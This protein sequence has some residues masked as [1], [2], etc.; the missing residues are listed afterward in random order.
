[1]ALTIHA[2]WDTDCPRKRNGMLS[3]VVGAV[4]IHTGAFNSP[5]KLPLAGSRL[6]T[7]PARSSLWVR[8]ATTGRARFLVPM[9]GSCV[10]D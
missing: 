5:L 7:V 6:A 3:E 9:P 10:F 8:T 1:M 4:I 2:L